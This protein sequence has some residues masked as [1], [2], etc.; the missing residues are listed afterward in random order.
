MK[1][2]CGIDL[3]STN[4]Y[5]V[6]V[7]E[8]SKIVL[9][10]KFPNHKD[11]L[12]SALAPYKEQMIGVAIESTYNWYWLVDAMME[13]G[14]KVHLANPAAMK[15][16]QGIKHLDDKQDAIWLAH[17]L[18]LGIL[19]EGY[20]YPRES[21]ALRDL[22]R[23]RS[24]LVVH[25]TSMKHTLQQVFCNQ[26]GMVLTNTSLT[27]LNAESLE[28]V[29]REEDL[30]Y[31]GRSQLMAID[32][33]GEQV[34]EI[35]RYIEKKMDGKYPFSHL[36]TIPG[37]GLI[38]G[39]TIALETGPIERFDSASSYASYC[40]CVPT[41]YWSN[42]KQKGSGNKKNGNKY[43]SWAYSEAANFSIRYCKE[44]KAYYQRKCAKTCQPVAYRAVANKLAKA[45]YYLMKN[46]VSFDVQRA[47][48]S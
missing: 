7:S 21:R 1:L 48:S 24:R 26:T 41:A 32:F 3:H 45:C 44:V 6:V 14:Y 11:K 13:E 38:L 47:F 25:K 2:Y 43:L 22:L 8:D 34:K 28:T 20:I 19:P 33:L 16:Y 36:R 31:N 29:L 30:V 23:Q 35:E 39:L 15:Q 46:K 17:L 40:R 18:R 10:H 5:V 42:E 37:I 4:S 27:R 9:R 12:I